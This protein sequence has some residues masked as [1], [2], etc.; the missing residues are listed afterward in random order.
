LNWRYHAR[1][2][3]YYRFYR[4]RARGNAGV[5]AADPEGLAVFA[6]VEREAQAAELWLPPPAD[7]RPSLLAVASDLREMGME[8][9]RF[10]PPPHAE[11]RALLESLGATQS[12]HENG[13]Y[14]LGC[15]GRA[16]GPDPVAAGRGFYYAMGDWDFI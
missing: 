3:R 2:E 16:E 14:F 4:L 7:W 1:P 8:S 13:G 9:W 12:G 6:F 11:Q 5:P 10:F 15:C